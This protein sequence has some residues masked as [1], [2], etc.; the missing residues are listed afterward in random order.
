MGN[1]FLLARARTWRARSAA[2]LAA[3]GALVMSSG[4]VL[5]AGATSA[6]ATQP[7]PDHKVWICHAT[8]S[9]TNPYVVI[10][11]DVASKK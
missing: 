3:A 9:D 11:V 8:D 7:N 10:H 5:M 1:K 4:L 6:Q 2:A